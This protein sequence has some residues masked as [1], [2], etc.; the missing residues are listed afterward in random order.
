MHF[1]HSITIHSADACFE[2]LPPCAAWLSTNERN[3]YSRF[4][5]ALRKGYLP[6]SQQTLQDDALVKWSYN[7]ALTRFNEVWQPRRQK[8]IAPMADMV[9]YFIFVY[10]LRGVVVF[11]LFP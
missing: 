10:R 5:N 9:C 7:V 1:S 8:L 2:C 6:L 4:L 11:A 3:T